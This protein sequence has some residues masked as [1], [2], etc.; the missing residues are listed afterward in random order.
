LPYILSGII[1]LINEMRNN[2]NLLL[3]L[4]IV[5]IVLLFAVSNIG[6][7]S[8]FIRLFV[9]LAYYLSIDMP[10]IVILVESFRRLITG[11]NTG[12]EN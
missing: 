2:N 3:V 4:S 8:L 1:L 11:K 12:V 6:K 10:I 9:D 7:F 5:Q